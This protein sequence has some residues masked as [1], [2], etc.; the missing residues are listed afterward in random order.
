MQRRTPNWHRKGARVGGSLV[1]YRHM[2]FGDFLTN[3]KGSLLFPR[4][5]LS[6][7]VSIVDSPPHPSPTCRLVMPV[8]E[9]IP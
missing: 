2:K 1:T 9:E 6:S 5:K 7:L 4:R 8:S 3:W